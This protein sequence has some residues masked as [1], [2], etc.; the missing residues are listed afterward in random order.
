M[1]LNI[2]SKY[3][4]NNQYTLM[5]KFFFFCTNKLTFNRIVCLMILIAII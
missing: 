4:F 3:L 2:F 1:Y 5:F